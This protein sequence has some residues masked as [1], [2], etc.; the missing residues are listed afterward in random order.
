[1]HPFSLG[2]ALADEVYVSGWC[3]NS[4]LRFLLKGVQNING[5]R[6][7]DG[8]DGSPCAGTVLGD[9]FHHRASAKPF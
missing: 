7:S 5:L 1:V 8:L 4:F 3:R 6:K 2:Q 9:N